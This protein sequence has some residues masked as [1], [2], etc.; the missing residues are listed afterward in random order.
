MDRYLVVMLFVAFVH[1]ADVESTA[2]KVFDVHLSDESISEVNDLAE[3]SRPFAR[4]FLPDPVK[5]TGRVIVALPGGGYQDLMFKHEG[6]DWAPFF[7]E[8]GVALIVLHYRMPEG[9]LKTPI[10]D[11]KRTFD[12]IQKKAEKWGINPS[13]IGVMG[14][15]AG[16]HLA[17]TISTHPEFGAHPEFQI[18]FY[19]VIT[20]DRSYTDISSRNRFLGSNPSAEMVEAY[21]C[22]K[23]V[24]EDTPPTILFLSSDDNVVSSS[25]S[26]QF[27]SALLKKRV[28]GSIHAY[29]STWHGW[30]ANKDFPFAE[31]VCTS[32][33]HWLRILDTPH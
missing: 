19:P 6:Y 26:I 2:Q 12:I 13:K 7:N 21:S 28:S 11:V 15:S 14:F 1:I 24:S 3:T 16:G 22:E 5:A 23:Q 18:L 33:L 4:C 9:N 20:M 29:P 31:D 32:L 25:N 8:Q 30:G 17:A 10:S 27:Y